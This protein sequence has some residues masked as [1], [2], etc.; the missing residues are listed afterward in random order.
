M[1][2]IK[3]WGQL[4][5]RHTS[6]CS[7]TTQMMTTWAGWWLTSIASK[8]KQATT[9]KT[10]MNMIIRRL[11][12]MIMKAARSKICQ[13]HREGLKTIMSSREGST[14][15][16]K[17]MK[18][19]ESK[20][21]EAI[22]LDLALTSLGR[23]PTQGLKRG[24]RASPAR[25]KWKRRA[26]SDWALSKAWVRDMRRAEQER[27]RGSLNGW[28]GNRKL[29]R[30]KM[31]EVI[32]EAN[33]RRLKVLWTPIWSFLCHLEELTHLATS[34][35][36][37][38]SFNKLTLEREKVRKARDKIRK[39]YEKYYNKWRDYD[40]LSCILAILGLI[41]GII[42]VISIM[43]LTTLAW[44]LPILTITG[45]RESCRWFLR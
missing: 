21:R 12:R 36:R 14:K 25:S 28:A 29:Q 23:K 19:N 6:L 32:K 8:I 42:N 5:S 31:K 27:A 2:L 13:S 30:R 3:I 9:V 45:T 40:L 35:V 4:L 18:E 37:N 43:I 10:K 26:R 34:R 38:F 20:R 22:Q 24:W 41:V 16:S 1:W 11:I 17:G 7:S 39:R 33:S 44:I 15:S